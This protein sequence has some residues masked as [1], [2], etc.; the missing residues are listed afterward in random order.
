V[1]SAEH[2]GCIFQKLNEPS[3]LLKPLTEPP[4]VGKIYAAPYTEGLQTHHYRARV[5]SIHSNK[6]RENIIQVS[7]APVI[8]H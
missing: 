4:Q 2:L 1:S 6:N 8:I 3:D 7:Y 5:D